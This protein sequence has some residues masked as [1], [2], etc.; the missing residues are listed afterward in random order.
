MVV[1]KL[2]RILLSAPFLVFT[3]ALLVRILYLLQSMHS[4]PMFSQP[5]LDSMIHH[6]WAYIIAKG[7]WIGSDSFFRAPLYPYFLGA[8]Y[9]I[10]GVNFIIPRIIQMIIG[11]LNCVLT[12]KLGETLF[13]RK[14]GIISGF[15]AAFYPLLI[16]FDNELL[17]PT[18][19]A[20]LILSAFY[21]TIRYA[22]QPGSKHKWY[23]T[24][25]VWGLAAITRPNILLFVVFLPFWFRQRLKDKFWTAAVFGVLG[26]MTIIL[27]VTV[28]NY[29]VSK[30]IVPIAWQGGVNFYIGNNPL[31]DGKTAIVPGTRKSWMGGF[32]DARRIAEESVGR[33]LKNSEVDRYWMNK[34]IEFITR[35]PG[36]AFVLFLKKAYMFW[37][38]YEI[39]NNRDLYFFTRPTFLKFLFF[40]TGFLQFPFGV[41]FPLA[42]VGTYVAL[43]KKKDITLTLLLVTTYFV[44]FLLFFICARYRI[45]IIPFLIILAGY[46]IIDTID[47]VRKR[48]PLLY[49]GFIFVGALIFFNLNITKIRDNPAL[50]YLTIGS[51]EYQKGNYQSAINYI[52]K[53][54]P[55]YS[56]D[57]DVLMML[58]D[59]YRRTDKPEQALSFYL[60]A[61]QI[62]PNRPEI[63]ENIGALY[64]Y[65]RRL[66]EAKHYLTEAIKY[67][68]LSDVSYLNLGHI[69][70]IQDSLEKAASSYKMA[71]E[72]S[73]TIIDAIYYLGLCEYKLRHFTAAEQHWKRLL[74]IE[75]NHTPARQGLQAISEMQ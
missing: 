34:G 25:I 64:F 3:A 45:P 66:N 57:V 46:A 40:K 58:A 11:A 37:G 16:Y 50:N 30:E 29:V 55:Q 51:I 67:N 72:I 38:G 17:I 69:Y 4:D 14:I 68:P 61:R 75:P 27:P 49:H 47:R 52:Q 13:S 22:E 19:L 60:E 56:K 42:L 21:M 5:I 43:K 39:P 32:E 12:L 62:E 23:F 33:E 54:M 15:V 71:L 35:E 18:V 10:F 63:H 28:R 26:L 6:N 24:G 48:K 9:A 36:K 1:E 44:S 41:L 31:S 59:S 20:F 73:P 2:K 70:F 65:L 74:Q 7:D 53:S 8:V